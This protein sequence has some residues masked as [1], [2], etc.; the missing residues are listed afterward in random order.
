MGFSVKNAVTAYKHL[1]TQC[2][3]PVQVETG[4]MELRLP[5]IRGIGNAIIYLIDR[6]GDELSI[7]DIDFD[8]I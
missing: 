4:P 5:A 6:Y 8:Y 3:E 2:A 7:Y 1:L